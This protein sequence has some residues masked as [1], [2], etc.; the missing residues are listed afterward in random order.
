MNK[1]YSTGEKVMEGDIV[2][3]IDAPH[4]WFRDTVKVG[5]V[6]RVL[7]ESTWTDIQIFSEVWKEQGAAM[8]HVGF[9]KRGGPKIWNGRT[10]K[11]IYV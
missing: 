7:R 1:Y 4:G 5:D 6:A 2:R 3:I 9:V 11:E 10:K 8:V